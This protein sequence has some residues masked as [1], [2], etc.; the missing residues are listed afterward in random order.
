M[1]K[2]VR[3]N[4]DERRGVAESLERR[5]MH[6]IRRRRIIGLGSAEDGG[7]AKVGEERFGVRQA[8]AIRQDG[9]V[10]R[11]RLVPV[12]LSLVEDRERPGEHPPAP[13]SLVVCP[14]IVFARRARVLPEHDCRG[15]LAA[16]D[17][18]AD[19]GPGAVSAPDAAG[20]AMRYGGDPKGEPI[21][22]AIETRRGDVSRASRRRAVVMPWH[23]PRARTR[24]D[25]RDDLGGD[26]GVD[27]GTIRRGVTPGHR[28][29]LRDGRR[30]A[31]LATSTPH[32]TPA[33]LS[34]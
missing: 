23:R 24:L 18:R 25:R 15:L 26:A 30:R 14:F 4:A 5:E 1:P 28:E 29:Y 11:G 21:Y 2:F 22:A 27:V 34:L 20:V 8:L 3:V 7:D 6:R 12:D 32:E 9:D 17:L 31:S 13:R 10:G 33:S 16:A 19:R